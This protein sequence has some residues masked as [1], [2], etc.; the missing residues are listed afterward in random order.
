[1]LPSSSLGKSVGEMFFEV[2]GKHTSAHCA[3]GVKAPEALITG[4]HSRGGTLQ[5]ICLL[6]VIELRNKD[7]QKS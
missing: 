4:R 6:I 7:E 2:A 3:F 5:L 1:M